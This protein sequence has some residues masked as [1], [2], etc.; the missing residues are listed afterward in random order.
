MI[1][2]VDILGLSQT[3]LLTGENRITPYPSC[4]EMV[5]SICSSLKPIILLLI[6]SK[7]FNAVFVIHFISV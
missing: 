4:S 7:M 6:L 3:K 1:E 5:G 2:D